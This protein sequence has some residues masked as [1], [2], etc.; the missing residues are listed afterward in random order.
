MVASKSRGSLVPHFHF[1]E[2]VRVTVTDCWS[3]LA[4]VSFFI[5]VFFR[6]PKLIFFFGNYCWGWKVRVGF[7]CASK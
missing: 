5:S 2:G 1:L 3:P 7:K 6:K 4:V